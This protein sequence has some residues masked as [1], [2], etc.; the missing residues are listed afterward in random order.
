VKIS[1][2]G[3][4]KSSGLVLADVETEDGVV[5]PALLSRALV[6]YYSGGRRQPYCG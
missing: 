5:A 6:R 1:N 3:G 2:V 4:G